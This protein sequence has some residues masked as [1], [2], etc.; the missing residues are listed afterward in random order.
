MGDGCVQDGEIIACIV[1]KKRS[2]IT[3][4]DGETTEDL[5]DERLACISSVYKKKQETEA[6]EGS[7]Q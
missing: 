7:L 1:T 3:E 2:V 5:R 4:Q 6:N